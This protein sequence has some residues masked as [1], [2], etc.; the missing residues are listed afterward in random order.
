[1]S[2]RHCTAMPTVRAGALVATLLGH[3]VAAHAARSDDPGQLSLADRC[4][5]A[6]TVASQMVQEED[7]KRKWLGDRPDELYLFVSLRSDRHSPQPEVSII[8]KNET[9]GEMV[10]DHHYLVPG[11]VA[12]TLGKGRKEDI[13]P[14][15][16]FEL[17]RLGLLGD[18]RWAAAWE[19]A[20]AIW[21]CQAGRTKSKSLTGLS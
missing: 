4:A 7:F 17:V 10:V 12:V 6:R 21:R 5:I 3:S 13:P 19:I 8:R 15:R 18:S 11:K 16:L 14:N 1:M 20:A 2:P 9:C